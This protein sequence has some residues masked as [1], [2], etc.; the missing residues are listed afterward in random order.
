MMMCVKI[1]Q[2]PRGSFL[3]SLLDLS[4]WKKPDHVV[5]ILKQP[6]GEI[7]VMRNGGLQSTAMKMMLKM[8]LPIPSSHEPEIFVFIMPF[9]FC[10]F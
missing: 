4:L 6:Y 8:D 9:I 3:L 7:H 2:S 10:V 5:K 1:V